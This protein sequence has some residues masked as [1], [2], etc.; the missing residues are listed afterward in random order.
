[1][2]A[3]IARVKSSTW[4]NIK[5]VEISEPLKAGQN[6]V[7]SYTLDSPDR[8]LSL[9]GEEFEVAIILSSGLWRQNLTAALNNKSELIVEF[10]PPLAGYYDVYVTPINRKYR[11]QEKRFS[12]GVIQ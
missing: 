10:Q 12:Y 11:T 9:A 3:L 6:S 4:L 1:M 5:G 2:R 7:L 8:E